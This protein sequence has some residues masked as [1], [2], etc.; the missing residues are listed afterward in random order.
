[1]WQKSIIYESADGIYNQIEWF[2]KR[3]EMATI[4]ELFM[5]AEGSLVYANKAWDIGGK[6]SQARL[7][8]I[9]MAI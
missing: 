2:F 1:M 5:N 9:K 3:E 6:S 4:I 8:R 7:W